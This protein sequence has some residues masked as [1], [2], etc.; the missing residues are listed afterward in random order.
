MS[1]NA[2]SVCAIVITIVGTVLNLNG[3]LKLLLKFNP[4]S[5]NFK[6][7]LSKGYSLLPF[8]L[9]C[10]QCAHEFRVVRHRQTVSY[11]DES[12]RRDV[13]SCYLKNDTNRN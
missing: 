8:P 12:V 13:L 1:Q 5:L 3:K 2:Q 4:V 11:Q 7:A 6:Q 9:V 10:P